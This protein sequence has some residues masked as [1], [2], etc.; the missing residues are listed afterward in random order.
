MQN[1]DSVEQDLVDDDISKVITLP[2]GVRFRPRKRV[3]VENLPTKAR[4]SKRINSQ[5]DA[6]LTLTP[7]G[8]HVPPPSH[9]DVSQQMRQLMSYHKLMVTTIWAP[10]LHENTMADIADANTQPACD[11]LM[12]N[13]GNCLMNWSRRGKLPIIIPEGHIRPL[14][15]DI[16]S[17]YATECNITVRNHVP[18]LKNWKE[19]K[20]HPALIDLFLGILCAKFDIDTN[21]AVVR[22]GCIEM[23]KSAVRQQRHRL[24]KDHFDPFPLIC[25]DQWMD[26]VESW[27]NHNKMEACKKNKDNRGNVKFHQTIGS[28]SYPVFVENLTK[29]EDQLAVEPPEGEEPKSKAQVVADVL[30]CNRKNNQ[31]LQKVGLQAERRPR[32][33]GR[34]ATAQLEA[35]KMANASLRSIINNQSKQLEELEQTRIRDKE[36]MNKKYANLEAKLEFLLGTN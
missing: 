3:Y 24:K 25:N 29:M 36:E 15:P 7:S 4:R 14:V 23:I 9:P 26:L 16:A 30:E 1:N 8:N 10:K 31:F 28:C 33:S 20:K 13:E 34:D 19:Y 6:S 11:N 5:P 22:N 2:S 12:T 35:E 17:K 18:V 32:I 21:D 27:K